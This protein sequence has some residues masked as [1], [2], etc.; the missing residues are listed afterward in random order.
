MVVALSEALALA[1]RGWRVL[2]VFP[3]LEGGGCGCGGGCKA[4]GKHPRLPAWQDRASSDP[5]DV[6]AWWSD[7]GDD[8]IGVATGP[9]SGLVVIDLDPRH[10]GDESFTALLR[11]RGERIDTLRVATGGGGWHLYF[12][13]PEQ[14][15]G[16][17]TNVLPG[18]DV[19]GAGGYVVGPGSPHASGGVYRIDRDI[20]PAPMPGWLVDLCLSRPGPAGER[21]RPVD[22]PDLPPTGSERERRY[23]LAALEHA[24]QR[25][26]GTAEGGRRD[27]AN[28]E[29]YSIGGFVGSGL[30]PASEAYAALVDAAL[31]CGLG[32]GEAER[33]IADGI[34]DGAAAPRRAP[35]QSPAAAQPE[36]PPEPVKRPDGVA[37]LLRRCVSP[38]TDPE[39]R[40]WLKD[41]GFPPGLDGDRLP[42]RVMPHDLADVPGWAAGWLR[43]GCRAL[44]PLWNHKG[45][46]R[47]VVARPLGEG[48]AR[49][50]A[51]VERR[52]LVLANPA[53]VRVLRGGAP[54]APGG[55][56]GRGRTGLADV[57]RY[58]PDA[59]GPGGR[60]RGMGGCVRRCVPARSAL[61]DRHR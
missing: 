43:D 6:R 20:E 27:I 58:V 49:A 22:L 57:R 46:V 14:P 13:A 52:R 31:A 29:A 7:D 1:G 36:P 54:E 16:N 60:G 25:I 3:I 4:A 41:R 12:K 53:A 47:S 51:G 17:R 2:P 44:F 10:G 15:I 34:E 30:L 21:A 18:V 50:P 48:Q 26:A 56:R 59:A 33:T 5:A 9:G 42:F 38:A 24:A 55:F 35:E 23:A 45:E 28:L 39:A 40:A 8:G 19:R 11:E 37:E 61:V 32:R